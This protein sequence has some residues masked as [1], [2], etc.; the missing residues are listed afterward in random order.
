[1]GRLRG[2]L[3]FSSPQGPAGLDGLDGKDGKPGLRVRCW[4]QDPHHSPSEGNGGK[5]PVRVPRLPWSASHHT[6]PSGT[7]LPIPTVFS[8]I[9]LPALP[10]GVGKAGQEREQISTHSG[11][12]RNS[13]SVRENRPHWASGWVG[14]ATPGVLS[15]VDRC[16]SSV[17]FGP[18]PSPGV[19]SCWGIW[20]TWQAA[21]H[22]GQLLR[23]PKEGRQRPEWVR[24]RA[25]AARWRLEP[26]PPPPCPS[27]ALGWQCMR[28]WGGAGV[29][30]QPGAEY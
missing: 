24:T 16:S 17:S 7:P 15:T 6:H 29:S 12:Q 26:F 30:G 4:A 2:S 9:P 3:T 10:A 25:G 11:S 20:G 19:Q 18:L 21:K 1:M 8:A 22:H 23:F 5:R 13:L 28:S 27:W 14:Q